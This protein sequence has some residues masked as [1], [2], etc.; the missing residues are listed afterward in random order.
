MG[1]QCC[2]G[3]NEDAFEHKI[4]ARTIEDKSDVGTIT[5][6][7]P[8]SISRALE[9]DSENYEDDASPKSSGAA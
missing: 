3:L 4:E 1:N 7:K 9:N 8:I 2:A 6:I 5:S